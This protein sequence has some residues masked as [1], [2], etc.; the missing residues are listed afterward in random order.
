VVTHQPPACRFWSLV[1][2]NQ[3][4]ATHNAADGRSSVN[5]HSAVANADGSVTIVVSHEPTT[6]PNAVTTMGY[7]RGNLAF[8]WFLADAVPAPPVV[9]LVKRSE[10]PTQVD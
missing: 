5:G 1:V 10:A 3:F 9:Q 7:P 4:M 8:R 6:H 2:W